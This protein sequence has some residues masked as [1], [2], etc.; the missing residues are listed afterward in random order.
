MNNH[1][2]NLL[3]IGGC[4]CSSRGGQSL[5]L[6][7]GC[8]DRVLVPLESGHLLSQLA[9]VGAAGHDGRDGGV[10]E[11]PTSSKGLLAFL[12]SNSDGRGL[13]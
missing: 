8:S 12:E 1:Q 3:A 2:D 11:L 13:C 4:S 6:R 7:H 9:S 5:N 10:L